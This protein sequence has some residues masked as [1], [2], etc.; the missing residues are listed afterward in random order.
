[1]KTEKSLHYYYQH[2]DCYKIAIARERLGLTR[3]KLAELLDKKPSAVTQFESGKSGLTF[4]TFTR[5]VQVL[6]V[7]PASLTNTIVKTPELKFENCHFRANRAV[8]QTQRI[9]ATR[10]AQGVVALYNLLEDKGITFPEVALPTYEGKELSETQIEKFALDIRKSFGLELGPIHNMAELLEGLGVFIVLLPGEYTQLDAF[11]TWID[12]RPCILIT[13]DSSASRMQF[14]YGHEL[15]HLLL[16]Q[17]NVAG[18]PF[19]ERL[20]HRFASAFLMPQPTFAIDCPK[21]FSLSQFL[22]VKQFWH[23]SIAAALYRARQLGIMTERNYKSATITMS[24]DGSRQNEPGEFAPPLPAMLEQA[25]ELVASDTTLADIADSLGLFQ[26][27]L[28]IILQEQGISEDLIIRM[29]PAPQKAKVLQLRR[30]TES[31]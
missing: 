5:L 30:H 25:L 17:D 4:E 31:E 14:N 8:S 29:T 16:D 23:V 20:A 24:Q 9:K 22:S 21:Y 2:F 18:D 3:K 12:D 11:A 15:A 26:E 13:K 19:R 10:Y 28:N 7:H 1:M 27:Q 6:G